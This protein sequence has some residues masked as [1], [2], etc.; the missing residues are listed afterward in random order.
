MLSFVYLLGVDQVDVTITEMGISNEKHGVKELSEA[1]GSNV[2]DD[3]MDLLPMFCQHKE[4]TLLSSRW[5]NGI[6]HVGQRFIGGA[7]DF[8]TVLCK[9]AIEIGF[10]FVY[11]KNEKCRVTTMCSI[12]ESKGCLWRVYIS[13]ES[14]NNFFYIRTLHDEHSCGAA[15]CTSKNS[16]MSSNLI[17]SLIINE[18]H[19][20]PQTRAIDVVRQFTD[21][22]TIMYN[23]AWLGLEKARTTTFGDFSMSYDEI[24]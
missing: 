3:E 6:A 9:Y 16:M 19:V 23:H 7:K 17:V 5:V 1:S 22:L 24:R 12:R 15:V 2:I 13:L 18:V 21:G 4:M 10:E 11:L 14:A 8:R 20:N